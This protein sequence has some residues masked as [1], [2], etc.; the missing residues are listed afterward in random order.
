MSHGLSIKRVS[1]LLRL[2]IV[3]LTMGLTAAVPGRSLAEEPAARSQVGQ[4]VVPKQARL[5][6]ARHRRRPETGREDRHL[7]R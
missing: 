1:P 5:R 2:A 6:P 7:P 4:R 3:V